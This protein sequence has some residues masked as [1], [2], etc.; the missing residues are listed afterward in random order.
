MARIRSI[1][2]SSVGHKQGCSCDRCG[3]YIQNIYTVLFT[4]GVS[5]HYGIDCFEK[6]CKTGKLSEYGRKTLKQAVKSLKTWHEHFENALALTEETDIGYQN[7]QSEV[8]KDDP[9]HGKPW[10]EWHSYRI[11]EFFPKKIR[12]CEAEIEKLANGEFVR[13]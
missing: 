13:E 10:E 6:L 9:F 8:F 4:D 7:R 2:F 1:N 11:N 12:E 3:Q 5:M